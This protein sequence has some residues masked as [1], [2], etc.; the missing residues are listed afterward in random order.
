MRNKNDIRRSV[1]ANPCGPTAHSQPTH[2]YASGMPKPEN[3]ESRRLSPCRNGTSIDRFIC[4]AAWGI[5]LIGET[6]RAVVAKHTAKWAC[7]W[8]FTN[9]VNIHQSS[10][11]LAC[12]RRMIP[13]SR[14]V[15]PNRRQQCETEKRTAHCGRR[16]ASAAGRASQWR[17]KLNNARC[18]IQRR[19]ARSA[20]AAAIES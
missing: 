7:S 5:H 10:D 14:A 3:S 12:A 19:P 8:H 17:R 9:L 2:F 20:F 13:E 15:R 11:V 1:R 6:T 4:V 16:N 18:V